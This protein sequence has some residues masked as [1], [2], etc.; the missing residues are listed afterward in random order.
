MALR[1]FAHLSERSLRRAAAVLAATCALSA[2]AAAQWGSTFDEFLETYAT[3]EDRG[4]ALEQLV[5]GTEV[6]DYFTCLHAQSEGRLDDVDGVL[7]GWRRREKGRSN[8]Y[9]QIE[10]R[11]ALLRASDDPAA[12][13]AFLIDELGLRFD[14]QRRVPGESPDLPVAFDGDDVSTETLLARRL[15]RNNTSAFEGLDA[16]LLER[17]VGMDLTD[18]QRA[19]L[20]DRL[21]RA[22]V[23]GLVR[24]VVAD[25]EAN[26]RLTFGGRQIHGRLTLAQLDELRAALP[27]IALE[28]SFVHAVLRRLAPG[29][30]ESL[31]DRDTRDAY[32]RRIW[33]VV[34]SLPSSFNSLKAH[35]LYRQLELDLE[36][37]RVNADRLRRYLA[38]PRSSSYA[39]ERIRR[40][41]D[42]VQFGQSYSG[43]T[44]FAPIGNDVAL[45]EDALELLLRDASGYEAFDEVLDTDYLRRVF[46]RTKLLHGDTA[47]ADRYVEMLGGPAAVEALRDR[48]D[49]EFPRGSE[50]AV[51]ADD[52]VVLEVDVKNVETLIVK[53]FEI[54]PV[55]AFDRF[56]DLEVGGLELDGLVP[57]DE[58]TL[59]YSAPPIR[60]HRESIALPA[61]KE[62]GTYIVELIGNGRASRAVIRK[63]A[64]HLIGRVGAA[65]HMLRV[66]GPDRTAARGAV[67]RFGGRD[68]EADENGEILLPFTPSPGRKSVLLRAG[69]VASVATFDHMGESYALEAPSHVSR[70]A[71]LA[72]AE[73][74]ILTRPR[75]ALNGTRI[76]LDVLERPRLIIKSLDRDGD[77]SERIVTDLDLSSDDA[78]LT[79]IRVPE[80]ASAFTVQF[81]GEVTSL[82]D[83]SKVALRSSESRFE[84]GGIQPGSPLQSLLVPSASGHMVEVRGRNG[85]PK[86]DQEVTMRAYNAL[87]GEWRQ[88]TL[89]TDATGRIALGRLPDVSV[90]QIT[91]PSALAA[92]WPLDAESHFGHDGVVHARVGQPVLVPY[93]GASGEAARDVVSLVEMRGGAPYR[94]AYEALSIERRHVVARG[95]TAG[96]YVLTLEES[97][98]RI[99]VSVVDGELRGGFIVGETRALESTDPRPLQIEAA[100]RDGD[101]IVVQLGGHGPGTR[102]HVFAQHFA[103]I[104]DA[105]EALG[106]DAPGAV[107]VSTLAEPRSRFESGRVIS[108]EYRYILARRRSPSF[109][110]NMLQ[111]PGVLLN[112]WAVSDTSDSMLDEG[113][114]GTNS[115][116]GVGG[117]AGSKYGG[118]RAGRARKRAGNAAP[119]TQQLL[120]F[121]AE[122]AVLVANLVPDENGR[123]RF[124]LAALGTKHVIR[125]V[126]TDEDHTAALDLVG[127]SVEPAR[128]DR[129][130]RDP[131][132]PGAPVLQRRRI[133]FTA[134]GDELRIRDGLGASTSTYDTLGDVFALYR[135]SGGGEALARFEFLTRWNEL[136]DDE[137]LAKYSEFACHEVHAFL[138]T[139][140]RAFFDAVVRPYL[141]NKAQRTFMDDW[142]LGADLSGYL[143]PWRFEAL[144][145]V[146]RI[147]LLREVDGDEGRLA[148]DLMALVPRGRFDV[149]AVF[150]Q[151]LASGGLDSRRDA[152]GEELKRLERGRANELQA[153]S[154]GLAPNAPATPGGGGAGGIMLGRGV[155]VTADAAEPALE[156]A[157]V[158]D[159]D[160]AADGSDDAFA[161][162]KIAPAESRPARDRS[163]RELRQQAQRGYFTDLEP[164]KEYAETHYWRIRRA[165]MDADLV[166]VSPFWVDFAEAGDGPFVSSSFPL[167]NRSV[168]EML[169][170]LAFLDLPFEAAEHEVTVDG[171]AVTMTAGSPLF[172]ALE[173]IVP[174]REPET[175]SALLVGQDFFRVDRRTETVDGVTRER[176]VTGEFLVGVPYGCRVVL[177][178]PTSQ[179]VDVSALLQIPEGSIPLGDTHVTDGVPVRIDPYGTRSLETTFYFPSAGDFADFPVHVGSGDTLAGEAD[180]VRLAAVEELSEQDTTTWEWISQNGDL[181]EVL[182]YLEGNNPRALDLGAIAWRMSDAR[183]FDAVTARLERRSVFSAPLWRYALKHR[184]PR[185]TTAYLSQND[186]V[187]NR[188][189]YA[190]RSP[191][192]DIVPEQSGAYEHLAYEPLVNGRVFEFGDQSRIQNDDFAA[193][194]RR[195]M[196]KLALQPALTPSDEMELCYYLVLQDRV[197]DAQDRFEGLSRDAVEAKLQYDYMTAYLGFSRGETAEAGE[198]AARYADHPVERWRNRFRSVLAQIDEIEGRG[199]SDIIDPEDRDNAQGA[200]AGQEPV[201]SVEVADGRVQVDYER[202]GSVEVRYHAMDIEFLFSSSPFVGGDR[203]SF[204]L[205]RPN[206]V[207]TIPLDDGMTR[208]EIPIPDE[209]AGANVLIEVRGEGLSRRATY[210]AGSVEVQGL[211]RYGQL[212]VVDDA[213][214]EALPRTYVKVYARLADGSVRFHKDGFTDLRGRFDYVSLSG[215]S[216]P[217]VQRYAV[218]AIHEDRGATVTE[219]APP[220][221]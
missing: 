121:L 34:A 159:M 106:L 171:R 176:Y 157:E 6:H 78:F 154:A 16:R 213:A 100:A 26:D 202:V 172:V 48:V 30:D 169:L 137:K 5:P 175:P 108:D 118:R 220:A 46:A 24:V 221:R 194:Y 33:S 71:L 210:F 25:F 136:T 17:L 218:L 44:P 86:V 189:G 83:A 38:L 187:L 66:L 133:V 161:A 102:V 9:R 53:V 20:L 200:L 55:A 47:E 91:A 70:E 216:G 119:S 32:L 173:D 153:P 115:A 110:G 15:R 59:E 179:A 99:D 122:P 58:V 8:L 10:T 95:L 204:G 64:L 209:F 87:V 138:R 104:H 188:V 156:E 13:Y 21:P 217:P 43:V 92:T 94:D 74:T 182:E 23:P 168:N 183:A 4:A 170:A 80:R 76:A 142:L 14:D 49:I 69:G 131:L 199:T 211:E 158:A 1:T 50:S 82:V 128:R 52:D 35:V 125:V 180:A 98:E 164:T 85:E 12:T 42:Q 151:V 40:A 185:A 145:V 160:W 163:D 177:T 103:G 144:N 101:E 205:V 60:R 117:G 174:A 111:R 124:P 107:D 178:N 39:P 181:E 130:L 28:E 93:S 139:K 150:G 56:G 198:I 112:P 88:Q 127:E 3:A 201:L 114:G 149:E 97:G 141:E 184:R 41:A 140:D 219:L 197:L 51:G 116:L 166:T 68:H 132:D 77:I 90:V 45:V 79:E 186:T 19:G 215:V 120:D 63:G 36:E 61:C 155:T 73:A 18:D 54:D 147:L 31:R 123:V 148:R 2:P 65:G 192:L 105:A 126:A 203:G 109:V 22:D 29:P 165:A 214:R 7:D 37:G 96:D 196:T 191:L 162:D 11:Q 67:L 89:K 57:S 206:R 190:F 129:R 208:R 84:V 212:K 62:P 152:L 135:A 193:Q 72:G 134:A 146:E 207:D 195:F 113:Q 167:A 27:K 143:D 81:V 75:L